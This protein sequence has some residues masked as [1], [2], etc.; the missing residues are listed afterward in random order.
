VHSLGCQ[1]NIQRYSSRLGGARHHTGDYRK[2]AFQA[3]GTCRHRAA[4]RKQRRNH[5][6]FEP[7]E[8]ANPVM[9]MEDRNIVSLRMTPQM[10]HLSHFA[11]FK[12]D[13]PPF[14][15]WQGKPDRERDIALGLAEP[16][17]IYAA[18]LTGQLAKLP[19]LP[20]VPALPR[21][22]PQPPFM[23]PRP[24]PFPLLLPLPRMFPL[25]RPARLPCAPPV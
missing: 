11:C 5:P 9:C 24:H 22:A 14:V 25:P 6:G 13:R 3:A 18:G 12:P 20:F 23:L 1:Q 15:R 17:E 21:L 19:A 8:P 10:I 16:Q 2:P 7:R 4:R